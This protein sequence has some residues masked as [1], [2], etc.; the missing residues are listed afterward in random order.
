MFFGIEVECLP[1]DEEAKGEDG[2]DDAAHPAV[3][4]HGG[5]ADANGQ[6]EVE[7]GF[8][9]E[10]TVG[11]KRA[12]GGRVQMAGLDARDEPPEPTGRD[13]GEEGDEE[14]SHWHSDAQRPRHIPH[15]NHRPRLLTALHTTVHTTLETVEL[16]PR[17]NSSP[18]AAMLCQNYDSKRK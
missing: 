10:C 6:H 16:N 17:G 9:P 7:I 12:A 14:P 5:I 3:E 18:I 4:Q 8:R 1:G 2:R 13:G 11:Q 15:R